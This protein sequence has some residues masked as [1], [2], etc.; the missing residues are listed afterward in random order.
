[1]LD[2]LGYGSMLFVI[3]IVFLIISTLHI[4]T[5]SEKLNM[6]AVVKSLFT[7]YILNI[8]FI[9]ILNRIP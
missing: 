5:K 6:S 2:I 3:E 1:M 7:F 4:D 8:A 9:A